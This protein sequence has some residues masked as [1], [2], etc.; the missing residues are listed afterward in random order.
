M[1]LEAFLSFVTSN[2]G[3]IPA[4]AGIQ[5][6][7]GFLDARFRGHDRRLFSIDQKMF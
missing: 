7:S 5:A 3:V 1:H 6:F 4:E 2:P